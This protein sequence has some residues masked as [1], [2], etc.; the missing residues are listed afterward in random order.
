MK[1]LEHLQALRKAQ[2]QEYFLRW[3]PGEMISDR[4]KL[5][6]RLNTVMSDPKRVRERFD[7]LPKSS[8]DFL[9]SLLLL[10]GYQGTIEQV[11]GNP[12]GRSIENYELE[13]LLRNLVDEGWI[14]PL[15]RT[16]NGVR[17][18]AYILLEE[19]GDRLRI[20]I[21]VENR[22]PMLMLSLEYFLK[23]GAGK[24]SAGKDWGRVTAETIRS[25]AAPEVFK[26][27]LEAA[28]DPE[29]RE[30]ARLSL[31]SCGGILPFSRWM[32]LSQAEADNL[33]K[34]FWREQ[35]ESHRLGTIGVLSLKSY[36]IDQEE[37]CLILF[38]E[39]VENFY[40]SEAAQTAQEV[41][42]ECS[43]GV[44]LLIDLRRF[45]QMTQ[46]EALEITRE[47]T[48]F[49][50]SEE[51]FA[52]QLLTSAFKELFEG[53]PVNHILSLC[54]KLELVEQD[55]HFIRPDPLRRKLWVK[56][57]LITMVRTLF[58][59]HQNEYRGNRWSF[60]QRAIR[61]IF[62]NLLL[63]FKPY[64]WYAA[65]P[66]FAAAVAHFLTSLEKR[67]VEQAFRNLQVEEFHHE[68]LMVPLDR[69]VQDLSFWVIHRLAVI[70][71]VDLGFHAGQ[72]HAIRVSTLGCRFF[73]LP[74]E[75]QGEGQMVLNPDFELLLF[76]GGKEEAETDYLLGSFADRT[77]SERVKRYRIT[78]ESV[79]RGILSGMTTDEILKFLEGRCRTPLPPNVKFSMRE[80]AE[81]VEP[82]SKQRVL[83][84]KARTAA[85]A[86][87]LA[88]I[89]E[90]H[91]LDF[92]KI[93]DLA[94]IIRGSRSE[95][96]LKNLQ[97]TLKNVGLFLE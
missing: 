97:E 57:R 76:P 60:H 35:L 41:D 86:E 96:A 30:A 13:T 23:D 4:D 94:L 29:L 43:V 72:F 49:K 51:R 75:V 88:R 18:D 42:R 55:E 5:I 89:L 8:R 48:V 34:K 28:G 87:Q 80:W 6:E 81:G 3:F 50:K 15:T 58:E 59:I 63:Q 64:T 39:L 22:E 37:E 25:L 95:K 69:L 1:L 74:L 71:L 9:L 82:I 65:K 84:L 31:S 91:D 70:G 20:T 90:N 77:A 61:E 16:A 54:R 45:L 33:K 68:T 40:L 56:K 44:D 66:L 26:T 52:P 10:E 73:K 17:S 14:V 85:G 2:L 47:G 46:S 79:K 19:I 36:G 38:Q 27:R 53:S 67:G 7:R 92:E 62:L 78:P 12:Y 21:D 11:R 83:L 24:S 93:G 32:G